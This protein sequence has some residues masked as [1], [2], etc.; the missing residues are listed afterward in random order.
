MSFDDLINDWIFYESF[1]APQEADY[2]CSSCEVG[3]LF[4]V[5]TGQSGASTGY[6]CDTCGEKFVVKD[7]GKKRG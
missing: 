5:D 7:T 3:I 4:R 1:F 2:F 6:L